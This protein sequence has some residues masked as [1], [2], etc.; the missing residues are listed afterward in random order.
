MKGAGS[1]IAALTSQ[2]GSS[3]LKTAAGPGE[4]PP[5]PASGR[6][7][8]CANHKS[9]SGTPRA[10]VE[11]TELHSR[12]RVPPGCTDE[13]EWFFARRCKRETLEEEI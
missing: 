5:G 7:N 11:A 9:Q 2:S 10:S 13:I 6:G 1:G 8:A 4:N 12:R 3:L